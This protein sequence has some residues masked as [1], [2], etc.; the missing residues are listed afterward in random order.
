VISLLLPVRGRGP[1][2]GEAL[3]E[4]KNEQIAYSRRDDEGAISCVLKWPKSGSSPL[5]LV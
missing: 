4:R 1:F 3:R 5:D 2:Q